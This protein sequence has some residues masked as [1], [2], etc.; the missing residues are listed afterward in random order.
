MNASAQCGADIATDTTTIYYGYEPMACADLTVSASGSA[1]FTYAWTGGATTASITV[2]DTV[3]GWYFATI[4]DADTCSATDS[5]FV[6]VVDVRCGN[7]N[8]KVLV[9]HIPPGDPGNAHTICISENGVPA[10]LAHGCALGAC[11]TDADSL[12]SGVE[13]SMEL[14]PNPMTRDAYVTLRSTIAQRVTLS[15]V[16]ATGRTVEVVLETDLAAGE[17]RTVELSDAVDGSVHGI[18]WIRS[19]GASG[20]QVQRALVIGD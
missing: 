19:Q 10:H 11:A 3:S 17:T 12:G 1:P 8:N 9:C 5:V 15:V 6:N 7:N 4:T 13:L 18:V 14:F 20:T 2:C 16:D